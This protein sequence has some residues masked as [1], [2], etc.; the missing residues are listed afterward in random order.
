MVTYI[1]SYD[2]VKERDY[3]KLYKAIKSYNNW[4]H[5]TDST[6]AVVSN[7]STTE[8]RDHLEKAIDDD[9]MILIIRSGK[10]A[11]WKNAIC[12]NDWLKNNL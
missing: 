5:I 4:A 2:L 7:K 10:Y 12:N 6:W 8:V 11:A 9:D 1:I 3:E